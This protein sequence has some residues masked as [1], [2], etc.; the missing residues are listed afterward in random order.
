MRKLLIIV[1]STLFALASAG[2]QSGVTGTHAPG[3]YNGV[4]TKPPVTSSS[5]TTG[6]AHAEGTKEGEK[7]QS[8][9]AQ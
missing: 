6:S 5:E 3:K 8:A 4:K 9:P 2:V 1:S 7:S